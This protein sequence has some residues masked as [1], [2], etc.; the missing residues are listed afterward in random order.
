MTHSRIAICLFKDDIK[1]FDYFKFF[2]GKLDRV[3]LRNPSKGIFLY[4]RQSKQRVPAWVD[5][6]K[7]FSKADESKLK[8]SSSGAILILRHKNRFFGC[9]FGTSVSNINRENLVSD[10]GLG[11]T[12]KRM[13]QNSTKAVE[14]FTF[15]SNP[16]TS[17][18][19]SSIPTTRNNFN[20]DTLGENITELQ[21]FYKDGGSRF[22][23]KGKEFFSCPALDSLNEIKKLCGELLLDY[24][25]AISQRDFLRLTAT[26]KVKDK[27][28]IKHL[29]EVCQ[30]FKNKDNSLYFSDYENLSE[31]TSYKLESK[32][33]TELSIVD[34]NIPNKKK[35]VD[36]DY[37]K[38]VRIIPVNANGDELS[39]W[40]LYRTL[41]MEF[42]SGSATYIL[43]KGT[44]YEIDQAYV[45]NLRAFVDGFE[46]KPSVGFPRWNGKDAEGQ[47]NS[48]AAAA[49]HGQLWDKKLYIHPDYNYGIELADIITPN[50]IISVKAYKSSALNSHLLLQTLVSAQLL[51]GDPRIYGWIGKTCKTH[52]GG[53]NHIGKDFYELRKRKVSMLILLLDSSPKK[54]SDILPFFS[55]VTFK[56]ILTK[57]QNLGIDVQVAVV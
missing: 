18:R 3:T 15:S 52:F 33:V 57:I 39:S 28:L 37:L 35:S 5:I 17:Q 31:L 56:M 40:S 36:S 44:W 41:F 48:K 53:H 27:G 45:A 42:A 2:A 4:Q 55:L 47:F 23:I 54:V 22:L 14:S 10:F 11:A 26:R 46:F 13:T 49:L 19:T 8:T 16:I 7:K 38:G 43:Y 9:C 20:I 51:E 6:I 34:F 12:F 24:Q 50:R 30:R 25:K 29:D 32:T 21:G 1:A